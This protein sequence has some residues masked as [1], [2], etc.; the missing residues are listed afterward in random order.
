MKKHLR[1][2]TL[3]TAATMAFSLSACGKKTPDDVPEEPPTLDTVT[4][5]DP[6]RSRVLD[7]KVLFFVNVNDGVIPAATRNGGIISD[8]DKLVIERM[9]EDVWRDID[10]KRN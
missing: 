10:G 3:I 5:I 8:K 4:A 1:L 6:A 9:L 2:I 7:T